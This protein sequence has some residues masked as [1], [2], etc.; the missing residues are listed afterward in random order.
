VVGSCEHDNEHFGSPKG[1]E[2]PDWLSDHQLLKNNSA[3]FS[4]L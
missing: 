3:P 1:G 2:F 4:Q